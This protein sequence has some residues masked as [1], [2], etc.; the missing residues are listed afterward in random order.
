MRPFISDGKN[1][2]HM[3]DYFYSCFF[4]V[5]SSTILSYPKLA[6]LS[7]KVFTAIIYINQNWF[8]L[9]SFLPC[10]FVL[11]G[12]VEGLK[13]LLT[14][15]YLCLFNQELKLAPNFFVKAQIR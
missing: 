5:F 4:F 3:I 14:Q 9:R 12:M 2:C 10:E 7:V 6:C 1:L 13:A 11:T 8:I 15:I